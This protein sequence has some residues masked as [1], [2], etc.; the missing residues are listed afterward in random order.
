ML[1]LGIALATT[2]CTSNPITEMPTSSPSVTLPDPGPTPTP[3]SDVPPPPPTCENIITPTSLG[4]LTEQSL[5]LT[6][7]AEYAEKIRS[8]GHSSLY[9]FADNGGV[10]CPWGG[11]LEYSVAYAFSPITAEQATA[12]EAELESNGYVASPY[13]GGTIYTDLTGYDPLWSHYLFLDG[14]WFAGT[15][16]EL[17]DELVLTA[18]R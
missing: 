13:A 10:L 15:G 11:E 17:I 9:L 14:Y 8:E 16:V 1:I 6:P 7:S 18:P 4:H 5:V 12:V 2:A 3:T